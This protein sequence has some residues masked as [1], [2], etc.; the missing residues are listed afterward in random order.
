MDVP[1]VATVG[2]F[3]GVHL[4]HRCLI[5]Q[6]ERVAR[7]EG[8]AS[9]LLTFDGH[10]LRL[11]RPAAP[12]QLL[13]TTAEKTGLLLRSGADFVAVAPFDHA[14]AAMPAREFMRDVLLRRL[15]VRV[16]VVGYAHSFGHD[17][18]KTF[19]DYVAYGRELGM[20]VVRAGRLDCAGLGLDA[21]AAGGP[22]ATISSSFVRKALLRGD[23]ELANRCLGYPYA[24]A[25]RVVGGHHEGRKMGFPT[26]NVQPESAEKLVPMGGAYAVEVEVADGGDTGR[27]HRGM[28]NIGSRPT[29]DNGQERSIEANIFDFHADIYSKRVRILFRRFLR[30]EK[31]FGSVAELQAQLRHDEEAVRGL[32]F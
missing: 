17:R 28:L 22:V 13:T 10:P 9:L 15:N 19:D 32:V 18:D 12:L 26:A 16:L 6:V 14:L 27:R 24:L 2:N 23:V 7:E 1:C 20:G 30:S 8:M 29:M 25:G 31:K 21:P 11:L 3:D 4:G 5:G